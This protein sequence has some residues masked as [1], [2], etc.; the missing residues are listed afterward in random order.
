MTRPSWD[1]Y[2][3]EIALVV[4]KR[5]ACTRARYG[6]VLVSRDRRILSTGY[7]GAPAGERE[8][9]DGG[10]P[11]GCL[12]HEQ[13]PGHTGGNHNYDDCVSV[14][15]E[16]NA[17]A[18]A[19]FNDMQGGTAYLNGTPVGGRDSCKP[20]SSCLKLLHGAGIRWVVWREGDGMERRHFYVE[21]M[22]L[23][24]TAVFDY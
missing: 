7:N 4:S 20:C 2:F 10:C 8:C 23:P 12:T 24:S 19:C 11:R 3:L 1:E 6:C 15:A 5:A 22:S 13:L 16:Q 18:R 17:I 9:T 14:H 21:A